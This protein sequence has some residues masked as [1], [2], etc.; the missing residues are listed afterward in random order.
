MTTFSRFFMVLLFYTASS[1]IFFFFCHSLNNQHVINLTK[2]LKSSV[3]EICGMRD[4]FIKEVSLKEVGI[5]QDDMEGRTF[6][7]K[8]RNCGAH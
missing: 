6:L 2:M 5:Y 8:K 7:V 4:D 3:W 1:S